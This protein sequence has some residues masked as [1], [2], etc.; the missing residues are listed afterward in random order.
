LTSYEWDPRKAAVNL[1]K[2]GVSFH[3]AASVLADPQSVTFPDPDH[4]L[5]EER[6]FTVGVS[7]SGRVLM[8]AH[9]DSGD[10]TRIISAR[11]TTPRE[12]RYYEGTL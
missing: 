12:R 9:A 10:D 8:V 3:E 1:E 11:K 7:R 4:S 5:S 6:S 2:H